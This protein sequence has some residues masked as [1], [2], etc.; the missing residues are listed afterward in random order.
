MSPAVIGNAALVLVLVMAIC[1]LVW[2]ITNPA[3]LANHIAQSQEKNTKNHTLFRKIY[4]KDC[5]VILTFIVGSCTAGLL[6]EI[7]KTS[8]ESVRFVLRLLKIMLSFIA[9]YLAYRLYRKKY[10]RD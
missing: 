2:I 6:L 10:D 8:N 4:S 5:I 1:Y 7:L 3:V 9:L